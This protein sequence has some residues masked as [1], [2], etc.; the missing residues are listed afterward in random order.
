M[1][2]LII[3]FLTLTTLH[4]SMVAQSKSNAGV[5]AAAATAVVGLV[6]LGVTM[7]NIN[8][9]LELQ[10]TQHIL[11]NQTT[12]SHFSCKIIS[13]DASKLSDMSNVSIVPFLVERPSGKSV[14]IMFVSKG[15]LTDY[16]IDLALVQFQEYSPQ[17]WNQLVFHYFKA[18]SIV[19]IN[20]I[21]A[22]PCFIS[23]SKSEFD[24]NNPDHVQDAKGSMFKITGRLDIS[25]F[26]FKDSKND[27][28]DAYYKFPVT[29]NFL[30]YFVFERIGND[31]YLTS[32]LN[33]EIV[34][35]YNE[36]SLGIYNRRLK[37]LS[38]LSTTACD[39]IHDELNSQSSSLVQLTRE[40]R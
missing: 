8:E 37:R 7:D 21:S 18:G 17:D 1:K 14:L 22:I 26:S 33:D 2:K 27:Q 5:A 32:Q 4:N 15:W 11:E 9:M 13:T 19:P 40:K 20:D 12:D 34:I 36:K 30:D 39:L 25:K 10:A 23:C 3:I 24:P 6:A 29:G 16:G 31:E 28:A 35:V 38:Q